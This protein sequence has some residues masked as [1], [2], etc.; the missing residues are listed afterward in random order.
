VGCVRQQRREFLAAAGK[1]LRHNPADIELHV[2]A[3]SDF[4]VEAAM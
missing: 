4:V 1:A 2:L 3:S